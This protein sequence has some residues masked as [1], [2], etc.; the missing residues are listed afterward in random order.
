M[1]TAVKLD[2]GIKPSSSLLQP[3]KKKKKKSVG[4]PQLDGCANIV[5]IWRKIGG[6]GWKDAFR[7]QCRIKTKKTLQAIAAKPVSVFDGHHSSKGSAGLHKGSILDPF[8]RTKDIEKEGWNH[9]HQT[10]RQWRGD[11]QEAWE[12]IWKKANTRAVSENQ[13]QMRLGKPQSCQQWRQQL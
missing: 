3:R 12:R 2:W 9:Q 4:F 5:E 13:S 6:I 7:K 1:G 8:L 11:Q 10:K